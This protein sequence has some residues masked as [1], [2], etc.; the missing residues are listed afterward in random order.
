[1]VSPNEWNGI[2]PGACG[3]RPQLA[4]EFK[5][6]RLQVFGDSQLVIKQIEGEF[7]CL[8][9]TLEGYLTKVK[10]LMSFFD[11]VSFTHMYRIKNKEANEMAQAASGLKIPKG[12][13]ERIIRIQSR[14]FL[15]FEDM[16]RYFMP[17][18]TL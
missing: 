12:A 7:K 2:I 3:A 10:W 1:M 17:V 18:M 9:K 8:K 5:I 15:A 14:N 16:H 6:R 4:I 11:H 13:Q